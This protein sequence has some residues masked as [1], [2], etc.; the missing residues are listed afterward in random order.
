MKV[1]LENTIDYDSYE[2]FI[3]KIKNSTFYQSA[4]HLKFLEDLLGS[5][6][7]TIIAKENEELI[8]V[9]PFFVKETKHGKVLNS[10]PFFG[11]YGGIVSDHDDAKKN[12]IELLNDFNKENEVLSSVII[13]NPFNRNDEIYNKIYKHNKKEERLIQCV[14][15]KNKSQD[16]L[17]NGFE[18]RVR[19]SVRKSEKNV[20]NVNIDNVD[21]QKFEKFY[22]LHKVDME[23]KNGKPKPPE[24]FSAVRK[25]FSQGQDYDIF[26][27]T[28]DDVEIA[29]LLVFYFGPFTEYYMPAYRSDSK[30][31]QSTSSLI[32]ESM[33]ESIRKNMEFYNFGG[34]WKSQNELYMF[35]KGWS[36]IDHHYNYYIFR[37]IARINE[38]GLEDIKENYE[39]FYVT[40]YD[41]ITKA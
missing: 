31:L 34:T 16:V 24:F 5:K 10:L 27:A 11:S 20:V 28:K 2:H 21:D 32:W 4:K 8:G 33:K 1:E 37:D 14:N 36:S 41:E 22:K 15:L 6:V 30:H 35:K 13:T 23:S 18:Q 40:S 19:R 25:H 17:W 9:F 26:T 7:M 39:N 12:I 29:Y 3:R 38:I